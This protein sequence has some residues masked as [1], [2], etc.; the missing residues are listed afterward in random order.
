[1]HQITKLKEKHRAIIEYAILGL[2]K[3]EIAKKLDRSPEG[4]ALIMKTAVFQDEL[5]RRRDEQN[6]RTDNE[7]V[8]QR[9]T[10]LD[11]LREN[12]IG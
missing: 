5:A 10:A 12:K 2:S 8:T 6:I 11:N 9:K 1:M 3:V 4:I 7:V